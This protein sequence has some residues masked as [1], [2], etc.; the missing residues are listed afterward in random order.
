MAHQGRFSHM[1]TSMFDDD[2]VDS[3]EGITYSCSAVMGKALE[4]RSLSAGY[5]PL[6]LGAL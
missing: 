3:G 4:D 5:H 6:S 1:G 2:D